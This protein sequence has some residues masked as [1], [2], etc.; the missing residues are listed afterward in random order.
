[1]KVFEHDLTEMPEE[2]FRALWDE[3]RRLPH[4][5][6]CGNYLFEVDKMLRD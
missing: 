1:M 6:N 3:V 2:K 4:Q 5:D